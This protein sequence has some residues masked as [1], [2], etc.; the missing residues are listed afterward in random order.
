MG[1]KGLKLFLKNK[2]PSCIRTSHLYYWFGKKIALD[3]LPY[4]YRYKTT[5][6]E[7]WRHGLALLFGAFI[8]EHVHLTV[9]MDGPAIY[10]E[11][12]KE[13]EKRKASRDKI[14]QKLEDLIKDFEQFKING[15]ITPLLESI[16]E[17]SSTH[18]NLLL[19]EHKKQIDVASIENTIQ[20]LTNQIVIITP[21][22]IHTVSEL[23]KSLHI[24]FYFAEQEAESF[25]SYLCKTGKVDAVATEDTDVLAYGC[26]QWIS[27]ITHEGYCT[28]IQ[29]QDVLDTMEWTYESFLD[30]CILCG[31]DYNE[32]LKGVGPIGAYKIIC[33]YKSIPKYIETIPYKENG[34]QRDTVKNIFTNPCSNAIISKENKTIVPVDI[35]FNPMITKKSIDLLKQHYPV[36]WIKEFISNYDK[37]IILE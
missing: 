18:R 32:T 7:T 24:P 34:L 2:F 21:E 6:G 20:K 28:E 10:K 37:Y 4:L 25:A 8:K 9:I 1:I 17:D 19:G 12:D 27:S 11:K 36:Q 29:L 13:R 31:T 22:D 3:L 26:P 30:F 15:L 16:S 23:C 33:S 5:Y 35:R 14:K